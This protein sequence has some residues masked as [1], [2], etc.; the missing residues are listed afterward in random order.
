MKYKSK[1]AW[2]IITS[3]II[4]LFIAGTTE[5]GNDEVYYYTYALHLQSN[6]FDHPPGVAW[7]IRLTTLNL[8]F[9]SELFIRLGSIIFAALGTWVC[10]KTGILLKNERTG[11]YAAVLYNTN[12]Y[13]SI[14]AGTFILPDSPQ[15]LFWLLSCYLAIRIVKQFNAGNKLSPLHW[16]LFGVLTGITILC[17]VHGIF[18][19]GGLGLYILWYNRRMMASPWLYIS[20][21]ICLVIISPIFTWNINNHFITWTYHSSRVEVHHAILKP[22]SF[23]QAL[24]GQVF[25]NNPIN[26]LLIVLAI[27]GISSKKLIDPDSSR[28]ILFT[29]LPVIMVVT[30]MSLF[31]SVLPHWSGPG[32]VTLSFLA[33]AWLDEKNVHSPNVYPRILKGAGYLILTVS[34]A[35]LTAIKYYPG[36]ISTNKRKG[37]GDFTLDLSGWKSFDKAFKNWLSHD[38]NGAYYSHL[39]IAS[40][41]WFPA[42]HLEYYVARPLH[43]T[44]VGVGYLNDLHNYPWLNHAGNDLQKGEDALIIIPSN[45]YTDA[46]KTFGTSFDSIKKVQ[47][48]IAK[49]NGKTTRYFQVFLASGFR[50]NDEAHNLTLTGY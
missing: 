33:A 11:L 4:R 15:I 27:A 45:Y 39:K 14:I 21:A 48:F 31:N 12:I 42:S 5:F 32:F 19:W 16:I 6:Y 30:S 17:K 46:E 47:T 7:L 35:G 1:V 43:T 20:F 22:G 49:R 18:L 44:V 24:L 25:Y 13:S 37:A 28:L 36:T 9:S 2:L 3:F 41:K 26:V 38:A 34:L 40:N 23:L 50:A 8:L 10:Y 29:G